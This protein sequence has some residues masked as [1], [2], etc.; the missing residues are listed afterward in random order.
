MAELVAVGFKQNKYSAVDAL[1]KLQR[2]DGNLAFDLADAVAVYRD[3]NDK[4]RV[5]QSYELTSDEGAA[6]GALW[7]SFI[8]TVLA[9]PFTG[10]ASLA[11]GAAMLASGVISG[12]AIGAGAGALNAQWWKD[13]FGIDDDFVQRVGA[14]VQ[15]G[16]SAILALIKRANPDAVEAAFTGFGGTVLRSSMT[17]QQTAKLENYL[18]NRK[19]A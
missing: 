10:G 8:G 9:I 11:A 3:D 17:P 16:D 1:H 4:L 6:W 19:A 7:G 14:L 12:T 5:Q 18:Q 15:P 13:D 2:L